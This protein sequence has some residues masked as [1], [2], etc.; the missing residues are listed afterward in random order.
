M[1]K[2]VTAAPVVGCGKPPDDPAISKWEYF[3]GCSEV[4]IFLSSPE[5]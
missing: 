2:A 1:T 4:A 3:K 5:T